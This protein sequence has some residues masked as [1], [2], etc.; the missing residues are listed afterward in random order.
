M[1]RTGCLADGHVS[2]SVMDEGPRVS[3]EFHSVLCAPFS[4][5]EV[6]HAMFDIDENRAAGADGYSSGFFKKAWVCVWGMKLLLL[7]WSFFHSGKILKQ[8]NATTLED[9][10]QFRPI[11]CSNVI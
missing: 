2:N 9:V 6:K 8:I 1:L 3:D 4:C 11:V 10:S 7:S 5:E